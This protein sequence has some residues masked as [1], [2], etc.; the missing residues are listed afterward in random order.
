[1]AKHFGNGVSIRDPDVILLKSTFKFCCLGLSSPTESKILQVH[2][3]ACQ[4]KMYKVGNVVNIFADK[5]T[6]CTML[7]LCRSLNNKGNLADGPIL[8]QNSSSIKSSII[9]LQ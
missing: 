6:P 8:Y 3:L 7:F 9:T 2:Q 5:E 4:P 1:M